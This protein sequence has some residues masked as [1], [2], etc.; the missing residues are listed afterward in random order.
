MYLTKVPS[1]IFTFILNPLNP[2]IMSVI[3]IYKNEALQYL[4]ALELAQHHLEV[5]YN[6]YADRPAEDVT[7]MN[8]G[9]IHRMEAL[10][11]SVY[12]VGKLINQIK[13]EVYTRKA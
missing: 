6:S 8:D 13:S 2:F 3:T 4:D 5:E 10:D 1:G 7:Y 11:R 12:L 9:A